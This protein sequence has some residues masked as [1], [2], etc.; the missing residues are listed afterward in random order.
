M[1]CVKVRVVNRV[2]HRVKG[3]SLI[4]HTDDDRRV[5]I[6]GKEPEA[7]LLSILYAEAGIP[8]YLVGTFRDDD[9]K[10]TNRSGIEEATWL[11][12]IHRRTGMICL[13]RDSQRLPV[14][15]IKT[16]IVVANQAAS[17][18]TDF[19]E[20]TIKTVAPQLTPGTQL[21]FAGL[22]KPRYTL[23]V[24]KSIVEKYSGMLVGPDIGLSYIP[25]YW[26]G[27]RVSEFREY[28]EVVATHDD[29]L[30][31]RFQ[32]EIL[33]LF[34]ALSRAPTIEIAEAAGLY[35][36]ISQEVTNALRLDLAKM[37]ECHSLDYGEV[38]SLCNKMRTPLGEQPPCI[39][40]RETVATGIAL[41]NSS[42]RQRSRILQAAHRVNEDYQSQIMDMIRSAFQ[43]CGKPLRRSRVAFLG[44]YGLVRNSWLRP[45]TPV[46]I[47]TLQKRGVQVSLFPGDENVDSWTKAVE[48]NAQVENSI[49]KAVSKATCT[50]V[51]L[52]RFDAGSIDPALLAYE[53]NRPGVVCDLNRVL[54]ASNV[55]RVGLFYASI[56]RGTLDI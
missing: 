31:A 46:I 27:E 15:R 54:E 3:I 38:M 39:S 25:I 37:S 51:A 9:C 55:E 6:V 5:A 10:R 44:T 13:E 30:S 4:R 56:G 50:I 24:F 45:E 22:C 23:S 2:A 32:E 1:Q 40:G 34:P 29:S 21:A 35:S 14:S 47:N 16:L 52:P 41:S 20:M 12:Q 36:A 49:R 17:A 53:M 18:P 11:M 33:Q 8:N 28:P 26:T 48:G 42:R 7:L 43:R 19:V